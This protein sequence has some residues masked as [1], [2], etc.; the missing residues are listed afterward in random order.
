MT[1]KVAIF[2]AFLHFAIAALHIDKF[3]LQGNDLYNS[4]NFSY[5]HDEKANAH[6][7][8]SLQTKAVA[9]KMLIYVKVNL[10]ENKDDRKMSREFL[11]TVIDFDK[12]VKG[13][14]GN[15]MIR[16]FMKSLMKEVEGLNLKSPLPIVS[17]KV[18]TKLLN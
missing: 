2:L 4:M 5:Y 12:L 17:N 14:Y 16:G 1:S 7:Y 3:D 10:A 18:K 8:F 6:V 9:N 13:L 15:P 11:R